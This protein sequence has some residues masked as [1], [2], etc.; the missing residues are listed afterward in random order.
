MKKIIKGRYIYINTKKSQTVNICSESNERGDYDKTYR[1]KGRSVFEE[2]NIEKI[3]DG[4]SN[5][6]ELETWLENLVKDGKA[7]KEPSCSFNSNYDPDKDKCLEKIKNIVEEIIHNILEEFIKFP[8]L[9]RVEHSFHAHLISRLIEKFRK[10]PELNKLIQIGD[11]K[12]QLIH[13]E[14]PEMTAWRGTRGNFD[15]AILSPTQ[16][17]SMPKPNINDFLKGVIPPPIVI[18]CG[19]NYN[20]KHLR[21]DL[22]KIIKNGSKFGYIIHFVRD[23][24][25]EQKEIEKEDIFKKA[26]DKGYKIAYAYVDG[27]NIKCKHL[28][29]EKII[30]RKI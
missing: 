26:K 3:I 14:W 19:L 9:H 6:D 8:Y 12:T 18:E 7:V 25:D 4:F 1:L 2:N 20:I 30:P 5:L 23:G 27:R 28:D 13:K 10:I 17:N 21:D 15:I 29:D 16:F 11:E 24:A 22:D